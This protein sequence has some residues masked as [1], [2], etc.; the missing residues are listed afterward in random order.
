MV[1][2]ALKLLGKSKTLVGESAESGASTIKMALDVSDETLVCGAPVPVA[3]DP[4]PT[5]KPKGVVHPPESQSSNS[6]SRM[7]NEGK[8]EAAATLVRKREEAKVAK[9][10]AKVQRKRTAAERKL[11]KKEKT[12]NPKSKTQKSPKA[13][14][15]GEF[16]FFPSSHFY[17]LTV[18]AI[19]K[20]SR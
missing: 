14:R 16:V 15:L 4:Q 6:S 8:A 2:N 12:K 5:S 1:A 13:A 19:K 17:I 3:A 10:A 18:S 20:R 7:V 11:L 9:E